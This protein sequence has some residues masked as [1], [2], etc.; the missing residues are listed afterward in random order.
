[1][2]STQTPNVVL[3]CIDARQFHRPQ[4]E[5]LKIEQKLSMETRN[6]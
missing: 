3:V 2:F 6:L 5:N 4:P 1:M